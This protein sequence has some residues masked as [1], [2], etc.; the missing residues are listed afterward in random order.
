MKV[1]FYDGNMPRAL[2]NALLPFMICFIWDLLKQK[3]PGNV[4]KL[5]LLFTVISLCHIGTTI[6]LVAVLLIYLLIYAKVNKSFRSI[7]NV[8]ACVVTGMLLSG[9]WLAASLHGSG[10][11]G[12][13]SNQIME[14]FFQNAFYP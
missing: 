8:L 13:G 4:L 5:T 14:G 11:G 3:K 12:S 7:G 9:V 1:I 2:I 6:M 10:A